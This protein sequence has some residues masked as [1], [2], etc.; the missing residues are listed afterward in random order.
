MC[1]EAELQFRDWQSLAP[2]ASHELI[3]G[4]RFSLRHPGTNDPAH[5]SDGSTTFWSEAKLSR[6]LARRG[7]WATLSRKDRIR[8]LYRIAL[9]AVVERLA[10]SGQ[11]LRDVSVAWSP[12]SPHAEGPAWD[13]SGIP[14]PDRAPV[15]VRIARRPGSDWRLARKAAGLD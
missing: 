4:F 10:A 1:T 14:F 13:V 5:A 11:I 15:K 8:A 12:E 9:E 3:V 7:R 2:D 6:D